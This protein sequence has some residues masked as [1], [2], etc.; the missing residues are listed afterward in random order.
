MI[1]N[2]LAPGEQLLGANPVPTRHL[3]DDGKGRI[4][5]AEP[6]RGGET[7]RIATLLGELPSCRDPRPTRIASSY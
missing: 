7:S 4:F 6:K 3:G 2:L 1:T 5:A